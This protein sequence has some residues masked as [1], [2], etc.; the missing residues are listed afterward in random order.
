MIG[1]LLAAQAAAAPQ[2]PVDYWSMLFV[3]CW[4]RSSDWA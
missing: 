4:P 3:L 2:T 1:T